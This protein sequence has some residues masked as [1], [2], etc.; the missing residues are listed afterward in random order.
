MKP[1][2]TSNI[3][4]AML[5]QNYAYSNSEPKDHGIELST[6]VKTIVTPEATYTGYL[7]SL[8]GWVCRAGTLVIP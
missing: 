5:L 8:L 3:L 2:V 4:H 7:A 6:H 1:D